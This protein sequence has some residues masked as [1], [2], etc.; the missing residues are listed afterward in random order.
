MK[1]LLCFA[2]IFASTYGVVQAAPVQ[3]PTLVKQIKW[4]GTA[5]FGSPIVHN[6]GTGSK[7]IIGTFYDI[8]VWDGAGN[9]LD[10]APHG[11][12]YPHDGRVYAPAVVWVAQVATH[13]L[14]H[15]AFNRPEGNFQFSPPHIWIAY[16]DY[17]ARKNGDK[18]INCFKRFFQ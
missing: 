8:I 7:K 13:I 2:I 16:S 6:L 3:K 14:N 4:T 15:L 17:L 18:S 9:E 1:T 5:W 11:S 10:R 12:S